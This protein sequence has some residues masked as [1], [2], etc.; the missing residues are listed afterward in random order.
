[1]AAARLR[2]STD[3]LPLTTALTLLAEVEAALGNR[4]AARADLAAARIQH[5]LL[6]R[7]R[8]LPDAEAVLFETNHGS[9]ARAVRLGRRVWRLAPSIRSADALGWALTR[10]GRP[11]AGLTWA[12]RALALGSRDPQ[13]SLHAG[14]AAL[15]SGRRGEAERYLK[16]AV[17][18]AAALSP[19]ARRLLEEARS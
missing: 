8:T 10:A 5:R 3:E 2:R 16:A 7:S 6:R 13:F 19:A 9:P 4:Q 15:R 18:G 1:V 11:A 14:V 12:R 17:R